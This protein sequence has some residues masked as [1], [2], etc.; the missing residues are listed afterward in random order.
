MNKY[1]LNIDIIIEKEYFKKTILNIIKKK[2]NEELIIKSKKY[3]LLTNN[4]EIIWIYN[5][6]NNYFFTNSKYD[7]FIVNQYLDN[8]LKNIEYNIKSVYPEFNNDW[9][10]EYNLFMKD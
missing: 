10:I 5:E 2:I 1:I 6:I 3:Y 8:I 4:I 9:N 7:F